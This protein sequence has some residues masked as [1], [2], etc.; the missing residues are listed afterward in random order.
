MPHCVMDGFAFMAPLFDG[1][2][3]AVPPGTLG[4]SARSTFTE[5]GL[6]SVGRY[7]P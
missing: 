2:R 4:A 5:I 7:P 1:F 6:V 3:R